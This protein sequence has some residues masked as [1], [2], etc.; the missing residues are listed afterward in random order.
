MQA[1]DSIW[2][3]ANRHAISEE[4]L[5]QQNHLKSRVIVPGQ[6]LSIPRPPAK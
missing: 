2:A 4:T 1:G 3:I 6:K 5:M